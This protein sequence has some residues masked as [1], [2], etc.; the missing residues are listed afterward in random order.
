MDCLVEAKLDS[1]DQLVIHLPQGMRRSSCHIASCLYNSWLSSSRIAGCLHRVSTVTGFQGGFSHTSMVQRLLT[2][3]MLSCPS[4]RL[5]WLWPMAH[6]MRSQLDP[7]APGCHKITS[8]PC[9]VTNLVF[10][11]AAPVQGSLS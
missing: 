8:P 7:Q 11:G 10:A 6:E 4:C 1:C 9:P 5:R 3:R 2:S